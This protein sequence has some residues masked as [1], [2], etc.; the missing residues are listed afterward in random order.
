MSAVTDSGPEK[1]NSIPSLG[2]QNVFDLMTL[3]SE[4]D[5][6]AHFK[7]AHADCNIR[8]GDFKGQLAEDT[9]K[10]INPYREKIDYYYNNLDLLKQAA[11]IGKEKAQKSANKT[12]ELVRGSAGLGL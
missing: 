9:E 1:K 10:F 12:I 8:Y 2:V 4:A 7:Q 6:I 5:V 3:V 11:E